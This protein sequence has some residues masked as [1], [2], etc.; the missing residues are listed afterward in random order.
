MDCL[1]FSKEVLDN[2]Y[3]GVYFV[4]TERK[5]TFWNKG[6]ERISGFSSKDV[7][8]QK[9]MADILN[10]VDNHGN[11]LCINGCPLHK[12]LVDGNIRNADVYLH[13]KKGHRVP[14]RVRTIPLLTDNKLVGA[15]EVFVDNSKE[16]QLTKDI[17]K[18]KSIAMYDQLTN[19][20]NRRYLQSYLESKLIE[21]KNLNVNFGIAFIDIDDFKKVND[22]YGHDIGDEV[23]KVISKTLQSSVRKNDLVGRWGGEEFIAI[24]SGISQENLKII[25][26]K[27]RMLVE[28][29]TLRNTILKTNVTISI[30]A[31]LFREEDTIDSFINRADQLMYQSKLAG[32]NKVTIL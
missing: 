6:A 31:T 17:E 12:T 26:E 18:L 10:H 3:E 20:A 21:F 14:I 1:D 16:I 30:G 9:C 7:I 15:V 8:N 25:T 23:L 4:N 27:L 22:V 5:I 29:S 19:L 13:H 2:F 32:K 28:N 24:F 11:K